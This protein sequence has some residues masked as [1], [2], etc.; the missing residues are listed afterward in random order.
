MRERRL[1]GA[2]PTQATAISDAA[3]RVAE[4]LGLGFIVTGTSTGNTA[5][6]ISSFRPRARIVALTPFH[7]MARRM[8]LV[9]GVES[10]VVQQ[11][12]YFE[13]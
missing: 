3:E 13:R 9:W 10:L 8:A 7:A 4:Q 6:L 11:Y 12:H 5:R 2:A 1:A